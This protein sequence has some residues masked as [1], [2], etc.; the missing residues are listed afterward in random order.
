MRSIL[1]KFKFVTA[2]VLFLLSSAMGSISPLLTA[3]VSADPA[4]K[5]FVCKYVGTPSVDERLQTGQN[6]IDV[7]INAIKDYSGVG[8]YFNDAQGRSYVLAEDI[9]QPD[10]DVSQCPA[11]QGPTQVAIPT[12]T[13][14][15]PCG[16]DNATWI[17]PADSTSI[18]WTLTNGDL[19]ASTT[20]GYEFTDGT[21][22]HDFGTAVDSDTACPNQQVPIPA[23]PGVDDP[24]GADNATWVQPTD[25]ASVT[26]SIVNGH[27][28]AS[29]TT[30][31][32]FTDGTTTHD[33]GL[34]VDSNELCPPN[35][36]TPAVVTKED[37]CGTG[38][39]TF[40]ITPTAHVSYTWNSNPVS[41]TV[42]TGGALSV[43]VNA[44]ADPGYVLTDPNDWPQTLTFTDVPC[45]STSVTLC[46]ATDSRKNPYQLITVDAAGA[47]NGH[48]GHTGPIFNPL[49]PK[50][51]KW[52]DVI[53]T[54][55]YNGQS[56]AL[57]WDLSGMALLANNCGVS[58]PHKVHAGPVTFTDISCDEDGSYT[59]PETPHVT[60]KDANG[61]VIPA[62]TYD[63]DS[64]QK[65]VIRAYADPGYTLKGQKVWKYTFTEPEGCGGGE[66][67]P[68]NPIVTATP[69]ACVP[70][71]ALPT[72]EVSVTV[73]NP[74]AN[75][76]TYTVTLGGQSQQVTVA[77]GDSQNVTF[78]GLAIGT[79][80]VEVTAAD[81]TNA[82]TEVTL[83][84]CPVTPPSGGGGQVLGESTGTPAASAAKVLANTGTSVLLPT[85]LA[86]SLS[87]TALG[88][89]Y[90]SRRRH[91][92][93]V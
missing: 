46:H 10:P 53:P 5:V 81:D 47:F 91:Y 37:A 1:N 11:A 50:H 30:G 23:T 76:E 44:A 56:Y 29:T 31:Y 57:N 41:G 92:P 78:S 84:T 54:F 40:T 77:G 87:I 26:W 17:Q 60:Y 75:S 39:D 20:T 24:C 42:S 49:L 45:D 15:D 51:T 34:A 71:A 61:D 9:G 4:G 73:H 55:T 21:T 13:L 93:T 48:L 72:G 88:V 62:G 58:K 43:S 22:V 19:V 28:I 35:P 85:L 18:T 86:I 7:S 69:L 25:S 70:T 83:V 38:N 67:F 16:A 12:P 33:Y 63:V 74:N 6:P 52:G 89:T 2:S 14:N 82:T 27:L 90:G 8:S 65:V 64:A 59:V 68:S 3:H 32:E 79:Y 36:V 80:S 66:T